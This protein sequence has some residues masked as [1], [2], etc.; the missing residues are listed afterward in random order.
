MSSQEAT[1]SNF[2][3]KHCSS[4]LKTSKT[5]ENHMKKTHPNVGVGESST[6]DGDD[7]SPDP[8]SP[9]AQVTPPVNSP[10][11][12]EQTIEEM[13]NDEEWMQALA[14]EMDLMTEMEQL[15]EEEMDNDS[16]RDQVVNH[17]KE[18]IV[19]FK[20]IA[21]KKSSVV[22]SLKEVKDKLLHDIKMRKEVEN[23]KEK[24]IDDQ[25]KTIEGL[26]KIIRDEKKKVVSVIS[27]NKN[28]KDNVKELQKNLEELRVT[29]AVLAKEKNDT[30]TQLQSKISLLNEKTALLVQHGIQD[31]VEEIVD[32]TTESS[33][34]GMNK[35]TSGFLCVTCDRKF[36]T[37]HD[38]DNHMAAKHDKIVKCPS[39]KNSFTKDTLKIH[40]D[41]GKCRPGGGK[42]VCTEC[43]AIC[44]SDEDLRSHM[45]QDHDDVR[46][47]QVCIHYRKGNCR[48]GDICP[49][50]H[51]GHQD[52]IPVRSSTTS[53]SPTT[54][55]C[56]NG[57]NCVWKSRGRCNFYHKEVG[58]QAPQPARHPPQP[59]RQ[60]PQPAR[61]APQP[62]RM[63]PQHARMASQPARM[64]PQ[65]APQGPR[66]R[67]LATDTLRCPRGLSC[68]HLAKGTCVFGGVYFHHMLQEEDH[69]QLEHR[70]EDRMCWFGDE[71]R[72]ISCNFTHQSP[73]DFPI[74]SRPMRP[75]IM[76][77]RWNNGKFNQERQRQH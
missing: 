60:A 63:A 12:P 28:K 56:R 18:K 29:Y 5:F 23:T 20:T 27:E 33:T 74:L 58:V 19:R 46:A 24:Q 71:C 14:E 70:L 59:A 9:S 31:D 54:K 37:N 66:Q 55:P 52:S 17:L 13:Y 77:Q 75:I 15:T 36:V 41:K 7:I 34:V 57:E 8:T 38:L 68:V 26:E 10:P 48:R 25:E 45:R 6:D 47:R 11:L 1:P 50:A 16:N 22:K 43:K 30:D 61:M 76:Q 39:C 65:F 32:V 40:T 44:I 2:N 67:Q 69:L 73:T 21:V 35:N 64:A 49:Y 4:K 3:C 72:R 62:A 53:M 42:L 51:V